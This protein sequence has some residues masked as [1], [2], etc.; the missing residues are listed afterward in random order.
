MRPGTTD[1]Q[2]VH[3][4]LVENIYTFISTMQ[5]PEPRRILDAGAHCGISSI[6]FTYMFPKARIVAVE[7]SASNFNALQSNVGSLKSIY[8]IFAALWGNDRELNTVVGNQAP[9]EWGNR[10]VGTA[11]A[12]DV[13]LN[14]VR[15]LSVAGL[16]S[17]MQWFGFDFIKVD[18]EGSEFEVFLAPDAPLWLK[19]T[20][21][22]AIE[23]H[24]G[25]R[26]GST[27]A[28]FDAVAKSGLWC[29]RMVSTKTMLFINTKAPQMED[30][31]MK[32]E[33]AGK[34]DCCSD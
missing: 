9:D 31:C 23:I 17:E 32:K 26:A 15:G 24:E 25:T 28:V 14:V 2:V 21:Y 22:L 20:A 16:L 34:L 18:I 13:T 1:L 33:A 19:T 3:Q 30:Y 10:V 7:A 12:K 4:V 6:L 27:K 29:N 5:L 8:P 11:S